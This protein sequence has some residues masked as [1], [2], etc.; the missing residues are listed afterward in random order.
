MGGIVAALYGA[1]VYLIFVATFLYA[2]AFVGN[3]PAPK[4][5]DS[6][7]P[8]AL[9]AALL[10]DT[11]LLGLFAVQHSVMARPAFK[12]VVDAHR[13][14]VGGADDLRAARQRRSAPALLA[15]AAD[16]RG[17]VWSVSH[18][19][20]IVVLQAVFWIGWALV[21][22]STFLISHFELFGLRQVWARLRGQEL[23]SR[24][25]G[26]PRSTSG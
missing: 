15:V 4:T 6:G 20:G 14:A 10:I 21:L 11:L 7:V 5:I 1:A 18:P 9:G 16:R 13:A 12:R 8:G 24:S 2:I 26:R 22:V 3:L 25:S 23:P 19:A 17:V